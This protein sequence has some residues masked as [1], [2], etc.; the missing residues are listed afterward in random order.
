[1]VTIAILPGF[2]Q[3]IDQR[4]GRFLFDTDEDVPVGDPIVKSEVVTVQLAD[5]RILD[6]FGDFAAAADALK[7]K[8]LDLLELSVPLLRLDGVHVRYDPVVPEIIVTDLGLSGLE[9]ANFFASGDQDAAYAQI[10]SGNDTIMSGAGADTLM[11]FAGSDIVLGMNGKDLIDG[12]PGDDE[13]N[14]NLGADTVAGGNG[15]DFVRGG[16]GDD[17][18]SGNDDDDWHVNGNIGNDTVRGGNGADVVRGGQGD[19]LLFGNAGN[20]FLSGDLGDDTLV[21]G[22]GADV[23]AFDAGSG[24]DA[25]EDFFGNVDQDRIGI[26]IDVNGSKIFSAADVLNHAFQDPAG[27]LIDLGAGNAILLEGYNRANLRADFFIIF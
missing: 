21:G 1:M 27:T 4:S 5:G 11:G 26:R 17:D 22:G 24:F 10:L 9:I 14:G 15:R 12:G 6:L 19:D 13:V 3:N 23:F 18:V 8:N 2:S 25:I 16:Q 20:D 7:T